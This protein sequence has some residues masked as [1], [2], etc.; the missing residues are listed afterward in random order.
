[1]HSLHRVATLA[2]LYATTRLTK[3]FRRVGVEQTNKTEVSSA[4][5]LLFR[6]TPKRSWVMQ[7]I[8]GTTLNA[9]RRTLRWIVRRIRRRLLPKKTD[10][11]DDGSRWS[12]R[13]RTSLVTTGII[14]TGTF[15]KMC[16]CPSSTHL[17]GPCS[18]GTEGHPLRFSHAKYAALLCP[19]FISF[20]L[21]FLSPTTL[22]EQ[23]R[24][25]GSRAGRH[26]DYIVTHCKL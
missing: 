12:R 19:L 1:M 8:S 2:P 10:R 16:N 9:S 6:K 14:A 18:L 3:H 21:A 24:S 26:P 17:S 25:G 13:E 5:S 23:L 20:A 11:F 7:C 15:K 4:G 22:L